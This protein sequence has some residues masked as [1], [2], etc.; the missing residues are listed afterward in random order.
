MPASFAIFYVKTIKNNSKSVL[1]QII[2]IATNSS[3]RKK[4]N[5]SLPKMD[6]IML[7]KYAKTKCVNIRLY[8]TG[9]VV[10]VDHIIL[11]LCASSLDVPSKCYT[12]MTEWMSSQF[13]SSLSTNRKLYLHTA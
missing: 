13:L 12:A 1:A 3:I 4:Y 5:F 8:H 10:K 2:Y 11:P 9:P 6:Y 7:K